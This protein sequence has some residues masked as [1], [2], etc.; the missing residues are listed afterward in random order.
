MTN[1]QI[2]EI[3]FQEPLSIGQAEEIE[4]TKEA[5]RDPEMKKE[6]ERIARKMM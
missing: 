2:L 1:K 4:E 3:L 6:L 5:L